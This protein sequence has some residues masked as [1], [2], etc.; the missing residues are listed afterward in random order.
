MKIKLSRAQ[1]LDA[2]LHSPKFNDKDF[3]L[4]CL[5]YHS[6]D[7]TLSLNDLKKVF[8]DKTDMISRKRIGSIGSKLLKYHN[9]DLHVQ[10][11]RC[12][13][14]YFDAYCKKIQSDNEDKWRLIPEMVQA[15]NELCQLVELKTHHKN[16]LIEKARIRLQSI[17]PKKTG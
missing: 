3:S 12:H 6:P 15:L 8:K 7:H 17:M 9:I 1:I 5:F 14:F 13:F 4:L 2:L 10:V 11:S 16:P